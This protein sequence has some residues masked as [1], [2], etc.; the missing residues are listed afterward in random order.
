[1]SGAAVKEQGLDWGWLGLGLINDWIGTALET[2]P[3][4]RL[5]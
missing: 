4:W 3:D 5:D 2:G 1:M